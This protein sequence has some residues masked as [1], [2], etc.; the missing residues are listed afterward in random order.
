MRHLKHFSNAEKGIPRV[1]VELGP[2]DSMGIGLS[3]LLAGSDRLVALDVVRYWD[4]ERNLRILDELIE[5]FA[6]MARIPD[7]DEFPRVFPEIDDYRFPEK[8]ISES[9]LRELLAPERIARIRKE[10]M[11]ID[12]SRNTMISAFVP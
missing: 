4:P 9:K 5:L 3:A 7:N 12:D 1:V 2:G 11:T 8:I 6:S 10:L